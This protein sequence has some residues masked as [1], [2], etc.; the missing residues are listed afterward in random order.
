MSNITAGLVKE[1]RE[2]TGAGMMD[3]KK[4]LEETNGNFDLAIEYLQKK[5]LASA[6]KK[7]GRI[8]ADGIVMS[9]I[10]QGGRIGVLVEVN[11]ETDFVARND[12][13]LVF[14]K[15]IAMHIAASN[16]L[17]VKAEDLDA[18]LVAKQEEIFTAQAMNEGKPEH[19]AK[20]IVVGRLKKWK[21]ESCL[22][23]Q[24]FVKDPDKSV[25]QLVAE[26][27]AKIGEKI[28]IRRFVRFEVGEGIEKRQDDFAAEVAK[29][30]GL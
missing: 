21:A 30:A 28:S 14:A 18:A 6:S 11:S 17:V 13:F 9:Y 22:L 25:G 16:P 26:L 19:I 10:H 8:A 3:C 24:P 23:D 27:T 12:D 29:Q 5:Q 1:L 15:D 7:A 20:N 4:A 2:R